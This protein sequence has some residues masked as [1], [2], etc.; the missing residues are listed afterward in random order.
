MLLPLPGIEPR[1]DIRSVDRYGHPVTSGTVRDHSLPCVEWVTGAVAMSAFEIIFIT[2]ART[3][4]DRAHSS[5][6]A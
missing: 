5:H 2:W 6:A 1:L 4:R 3:N